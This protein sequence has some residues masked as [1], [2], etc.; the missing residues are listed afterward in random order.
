MGKEPEVLGT[1]AALKAATASKPVKGLSGVYVVY[2]DNVVEAPEVTDFAP[3]KKQ[4][5]QTLSSR[6][7]YE[8]YEA[9][10][11]KAEVKDNRV[12]FY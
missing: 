12:K 7:D 4:L 3:A 5:A 6:A 9:L 1:I 2:V 8:V 10:K 11:D